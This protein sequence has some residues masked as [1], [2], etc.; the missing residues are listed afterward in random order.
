[1]TTTEFL[2]SINFVVD[3]S[4]LE[5][6]AT[7][8]DSEISAALAGQPSSL[9][10]LPAGLGS[11]LHLSSRR[12]AV[13]DAGGTNLRV[14]EVEI[15]ED[16]G[17]PI[18]RHVRKSAMPGTYGR[19]SA[20]EFHQAIASEVETV[21][22]AADGLDRLGYCFSYECRSLPDGDAELLAWSKQIDAP[23]VVGQQV[24]AELSRRLT[25]PPASLKVL[26]DTVATLLAGCAK[27][28]AD[29]ASGYLGFILGTGTNV[30]CSEQGMLRNAESGEFN[31][32]VRS[33]ADLALDAQTSDP[34][35]AVFEKMVAG[36]YLG[37]LGLCLFREAA[38]QGLL[39]SG[40]AG[41]LAG[42]SAL[43]TKS[44][45][46]F[47]AGDLPEEMAGLFLAED[48]PVARELALAVFRRAAN[49]TAAHLAAFLRRTASLEAKA[50]V[51]LTVDGSTFWKT[52][53]LPFEKEVAAK[54]SALPK[55]P[56]YRII[57]VEEA[58]MVGAAVAACQSR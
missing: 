32:L 51:V 45:D 50:P 43:E 49:L 19:L 11:D 37:T 4:D 15:R 46:V 42:L 16:G 14:A 6:V 3:G 52:R 36:A 39:S 47:A 23:D 1:M 29:Q 35:C 10:M 20:A 9:R 22:A 26:N 5:T 57:Q 17:D 18:F 41:R 38:R 25:R 44:L 30:A 55:V 34:G 2:A 8:F 28:G 33:S 13:I 48:L 27:V 58:P 53:C 12:A 40:T 31:K 24:G 54:L 56:P 7:A 21:F